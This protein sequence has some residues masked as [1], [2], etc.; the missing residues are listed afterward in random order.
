MTWLGEAMAGFKAMDQ[1]RKWYLLWRHPSV[2]TRFVRLFENH[3]VH[4]NQIPRFIGHGLTLQDVQDDA[5]LLPKLDEKLLAAVCERFAVRREWLDGVDSQIHPCLDF[6]KHSKEFS[7][8]IRDLKAM[9]PDG[10]IT[11]VLIAPN[12]RV[13]QANALLILQEAVGSVGEKPIY[14]YHLC[15]NW[16]FTYWKARAYLTACIAIA[17][18]Q[19]VFIHGIYMPK[20]GIER[21][22]EGK[23]LLGWQGEGIWKL[24]H[25][26][27]NPEDMTLQPEAF[28]NG[29]D[30]ER[31]NY[32]IKSGLGLW[33]DLEQQG[34]M[35]ADIK[36]NA[37]Q[38]FQQEFAKY[39][40]AAS[41][42]VAHTPFSQE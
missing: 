16:A 36:A 29:V 4:R 40:S 31:D 38:L 30:P 7:V 23:T 25:K 2:V 1:L 21:L 9:N 37:R 18:K 12:E 22:A 27:W 5:S 17:W 32:G 19:H 6:Y 35:D 10:A 24:G 14:R 26:T 3:G 8:L 34:F 33:L 41:N 13:W 15:N 11:G 42:G 39:S 28:L 20:K